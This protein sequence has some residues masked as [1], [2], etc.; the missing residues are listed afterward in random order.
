MTAATL[1][2]DP[3]PRLTPLRRMGATHPPLLIAAVSKASDQRVPPSDAVP[4]LKIRHPQPT[5]RKHRVGARRPVL[6]PSVTT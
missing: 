2:L 3:D 5:R 4:L 6:F 1:S